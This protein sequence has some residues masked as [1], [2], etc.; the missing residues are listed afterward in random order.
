MI[1]CALFVMLMA[2]LAA[3]ARGDGGASATVTTSVAVTATTGRGA[4]GPAS[5]TAP[6]G[7]VSAPVTTEPAIS[8]PP[9]TDDPGIPP[10]M[11]TYYIGFLKKGPVWAPPTPE[12]EAALNELQQRHMAHIREMGDTKKLVMAGP[13]IDGGD[14]RGILIF[15]TATMEEA[16][17]MAQDDPAVEAGRLVVE[18]HPWL[19]MRGILPDPEA[20]GPPAPGGEQK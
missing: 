2:G 15:R 16:I 6:A 4:T 13:F 5:A 18:M 11:T 3:P 1:R 20:V 17:A 9:V 14:I 7:G 19:T 8:N 10:N 12:T